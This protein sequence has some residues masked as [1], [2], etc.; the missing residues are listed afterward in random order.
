MRRNLFVLLLAALAVAATPAATARTAKTVSVS[1]TGSAFV[2]KNVTVDAGDTVT[3][4]NKDTA[5]HQVVCQK[6]PFTSPTLKP[7]ESFSYTFVDQGKFAITD[8]LKSTIKGTITVNQGVTL[9]A[10]PTIVTFGGTTTLSGKV[11]SNA[12][13]EKVIILGKQ[14]G[15]LAFSSISTL[16]TTGGGKYSTSVAPAKNTSYEAKWR[17]TTSAIVTVKVRPKMRLSEPSSHHFRVRVRAAQSFAGKTAVFQRYSTI[18]KTWVS[19]KLVTL[20]A[21]T[22]AGSVQVSGRTFRSRV[23]SGLKVRM[24][25]RSSQTAPC[26]SAGRSNV[27]TV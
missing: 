20:K 17:T 19:V 23:H 21:I 6:C 2:P 10:S 25:M 27:I 12:A 26:Y 22:V 13:G 16:T 7:N 18:K 3:W 5:N 1:I 15:A 11:S 4:T 8:A 9:T 14:C 24:I